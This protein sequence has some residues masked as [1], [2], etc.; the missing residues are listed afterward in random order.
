ML[1]REALV[2]RAWEE[3]ELYAAVAEAAEQPDASSAEGTPATAAV[4]VAVKEATV[5]HDTFLG[6]EHLL[7]GLL[8]DAAG[9]SAALFERLGVRAAV[10]AVVVGLLDEPG[11]A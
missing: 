10:R 4:K 1:Q 2:V 8:D 6:G 7:W 9:E 5:R 11:T 3:K